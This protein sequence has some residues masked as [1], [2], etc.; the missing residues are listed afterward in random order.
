M[1]NRRMLLPVL[2]SDILTSKF[3]RPASVAKASVPAYMLADYAIAG[4]TIDN[5]NLASVMAVDASSAMAGEQVMPI[6]VV[7]CLNTVGFRAADAM[8]TT[9]SEVELAKL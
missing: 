7:G 9:D 4:S 8:V 1:K 5:P 6:R 2:V 3:T